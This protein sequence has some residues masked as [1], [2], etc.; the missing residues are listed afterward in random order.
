MAKPKVLIFAPA[1]ETHPELEAAGCEIVVGAASWSDPTGDSQGKLVEMAADAEALV[2][3]S[4]KGSGINRDVLMASEA[5]RIVA[6][7]TVGV[8]EIDGK[9]G[10][11]SWQSP[12]GKALLGK[13][14]DDTVV[15]K[16]HAGQR[17]L[18]VIEVDYK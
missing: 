2:G 18:T 7:Y 15:V 9:S 6:K 4:I 11:I 5:L 3:T 16:W 13:G 12:V 17:E 14:I 1:T 8:D 10:D